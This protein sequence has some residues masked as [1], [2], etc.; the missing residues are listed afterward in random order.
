MMRVARQTV[1]IACFI[2]F[3]MAPAWGIEYTG[4]EGRDPFVSRL[5]RPTV[6]SA[7]SGSARD[8]NSDRPSFS[9]EGIIWVPEKP[10]ALINGK[11]VM[12][13]SEV[14][15]AKIVEIKKKEVKILS[16]GQEITL[17]ATNGG[18]NEAA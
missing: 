13:G 3:M 4:Q 14:D 7:A 11:R 12:V 8:T 5:V 10:R 15:G 17:F 6:D 1:E 9:L 2:F 16:N 18:L